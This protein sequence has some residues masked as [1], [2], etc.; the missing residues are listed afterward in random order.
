MAKS[1][2]RY[3]IGG[4][5]GF[6]NPK[7]EETETFVGPITRKAKFRRH[8]RRFWCIYLIGS[9]VF[10]AIFLP[11]FFLVAIPAIARL[12]IKNADLRVVSAAVMNPTPD[13][14]RMSLETKVNLKLA[15]GVRLDP[16]TFD[17]FVRSSGH[18]HPW[19]GVKIPGQTIKGNYSLIVN[20]QLTPLLN[21]TTWETFIREAVF[22]KE[23]YLSLYADAT[24]Y[25]G[26]LKNHLTLDK[27]IKIR[28]L[29]KFEGF[30]ISDSTLL[31]PA[32]DDG[33]NLIANITLPNP[34]PLS[35][36]VGTLTL[37]LKGSESGPIIGNATVR[38]VV[39]TPGN[40]TFPIA[41]FLDLKSTLGGLPNLLASQGATLENGTMSLTAVTS[42]IVYNGTFIPGYTNVLK[43]LPL[44][45]NV[46]I[47]D[48]LRNTLSHMGMDGNVNLTEAMSTLS[49]SLKRRGDR[50]PAQLGPVG[51]GDAYNQIASLKHN[52]HV[53]KVLEDE[54]PEERDALID[55]FARYVAS[56]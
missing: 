41:G 22:Q 36:E 32:A 16:V 18:E 31:I 48:I 51:Y 25:L 27:D 30:T 49:G 10:L 7:L 1:I 35:F 37:D 9:V 26:A 40:N 56:L 47:A 54:D 45:A 39:L 50:D 15:L 33:T 42:S 24:G 29:N 55:S 52:K 11:V 44:V 8:C 38:N 12:V 34:S 13:T 2:G 43:Q 6:L 28:T 19:A 4:N 23:T 46:G 3:I 17:V 53:Q 21:Q 5:R 20:D 14:V